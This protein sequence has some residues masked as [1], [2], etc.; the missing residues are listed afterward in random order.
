MEDPRNQHPE[1]PREKTGARILLI[2]DNEG[3]I[4][5]LSMALD[6]A[7][8]DHTLTTVRDG[9][10]ARDLLNSVDSAQAIPPDLILM[11]LNLPRVDGTVLIDL[12]RSRPRLQEI[13]VVLLSS[14]SSPRDV[15]RAGDLRRSIFIVKPSY[16]S[17]FMDIGKRVREFLENSREMAR[18]ANP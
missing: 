17:A 13:P 4:Y 11:D 8:F 15:A 9:A 2:E 12:L 1:A 5:L 10:E 6:D 7:N 16:L 14:S 18:S 3:D